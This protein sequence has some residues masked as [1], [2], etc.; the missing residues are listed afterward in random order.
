[1]RLLI[2]ISLFISSVVL[3]QNKAEK[4]SRHLIGLNANTISGVGPSYRFSYRGFSTQATFSGYIIGSRTKYNV[5]FSLMH[6]FDR[7]KN[8]QIDFGLSCRFKQLG[9]EEFEPQGEELVLKEVWTE[10]LN[11]GFHFD[12]LRR[13][14]KKIQ[15]NISLGYGIYNL[16]GAVVRSTDY[17]Y[18]PQNLFERI[19][20]FRLKN[21]GTFPTIGIALYYKLN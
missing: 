13:F 9:D 1:M 7:L 18:Y 15:L 2:L 8:G 10:Q 14:G 20:T 6:R 16:L 3:S 11:T 4:E 21:L 5:G 12:Y 17:N 19:L